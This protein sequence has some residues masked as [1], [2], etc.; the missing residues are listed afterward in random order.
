VRRDS[1]QQPGDD[2]TTIVAEETIERGRD[3]ISAPSATKLRDMFRFPVVTRRRQQWRKN[4]AG[5]GR[6]NIRFGERDRKSQNKKRDKKHAGKRCPAILVHR[7]RTITTRTIAE[8]VTAVTINTYG[9]FVIIIYYL[10]ITLAIVLFA[11]RVYSF[12]CTRIY[13]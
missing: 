4:C 7:E 6:T 5:N 13:I 9:F 2:R 11:T 1:Q 10:Q 3:S 12:F 8:T